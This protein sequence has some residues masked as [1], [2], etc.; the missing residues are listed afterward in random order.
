MINFFFNF[1]VLKNGLS[2][3]LLDDEV[4]VVPELVAQ[5][6][7]LGLPLVLEAELEG[8]LGDV[9]EVKLLTPFFGLSIIIFIQTYQ[10]KFWG[11]IFF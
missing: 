3:H 1:L 10:T 4:Q 6:P 8:L 9:I 11:V 5:L 7:E 2:P